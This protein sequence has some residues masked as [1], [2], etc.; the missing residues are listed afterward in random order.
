[1]AWNDNMLEAYISWW[2]SCLPETISAWIYTYTYSDFILC[3]RKTF[4]FC[5]L[6]HTITTCSLGYSMTLK[7]LK[8][9]MCPNSFILNLM[10]W[11]NLL[12]S[13]F[14]WQKVS[15]LANWQNCCSWQWLLGFQRACWAQKLGGISLSTHQEALLLAKVC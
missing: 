12:A 11:G 3:P 5:S 8:K 4:S 14:V 9:K 2:V 10:S 6:N 7:L 1:M 13:L 15:A